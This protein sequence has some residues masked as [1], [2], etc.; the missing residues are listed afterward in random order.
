MFICIGGDLDGEVVNNREGT[1]FKASE[2]D[3]SKESTYNRQSYII[4]ENTYRFWLCAE[5][6]YAETTKIANDYLAQK[7][8]YLS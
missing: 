2:I 7:H 5:L 3:T 1:F 6:T 8:P 4:G